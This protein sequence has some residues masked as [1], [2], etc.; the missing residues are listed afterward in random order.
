MNSFELFETLVSFGLSVI[1]LTIITIWTTIVGW[2]VKECLE[3]QKEEPKLSEDEVFDF[4]EE[5]VD[6]EIT[7]EPLELKPLKRFKKWRKKKLKPPQT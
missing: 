3:K 2:K 1:T 5:G 7:E 6:E 4:V